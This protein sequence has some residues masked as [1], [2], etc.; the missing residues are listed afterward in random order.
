MKANMDALP[1]L[2]IAISNKVIK[3]DDTVKHCDF[4]YKD[5]TRYTLIWS[6]DKSVPS[7]LTYWGKNGKN[8]I[9]L[10]NTKKDYNAWV[11]EVVDIFKG[12]DLS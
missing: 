12:Q 9:P 8:V 6:K 5:Y 10:K 11:K 1:E 2:V 3:V 4:A 7:S